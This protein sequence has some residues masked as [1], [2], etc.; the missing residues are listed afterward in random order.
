MYVSRSI[1]AIQNQLPMGSTSHPEASPQPVVPSPI[2]DCL[3][4]WASSRTSFKKT[5]SLR[6]SDEALAHKIQHLRHE[7][8]KE[9]RTLAAESGWNKPELKGAFRNALNKNIKDDLTSQEEP[10]SL[11]DLTESM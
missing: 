10:H 9:F 4:H 3:H 8:T 11:D 2:A 7:M 6:H 5:F 1:Q